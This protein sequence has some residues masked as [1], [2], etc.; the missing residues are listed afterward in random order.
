MYSS[1]RIVNDGFAHVHLVRSS[2]SFTCGACVP[3]FASVAMS[4][5]YPPC[6]PSLPA[7]RRGRPRIDNV[8]PVQL[9]PAHQS[10]LL[11]GARVLQRPTFMHD[12]LQFTY[13]LFGVAVVI[14]H[15]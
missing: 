6:P 2:S 4:R 8:T 7:N 10:N 1:F 12:E 3:L 5:R 15:W 13:N 11:G 9:R 14:G